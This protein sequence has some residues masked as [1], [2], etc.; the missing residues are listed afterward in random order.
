MI[1]GGILIL[2]VGS[3]CAGGTVASPSAAEATSSTL[4][5]TATA[6]PSATATSAAALPTELVGN[7]RTD[8]TDHLPDDQI[9]EM[10]GSEVRLVIRA[11]GTTT[12]SRGGP[13][14]DRRRF[15]PDVR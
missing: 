8:L 6:E 15:A 3:G 1:L 13:G 2:I 14:G 10:F 9:D 4:G 12:I 5:A 11:D 7:W